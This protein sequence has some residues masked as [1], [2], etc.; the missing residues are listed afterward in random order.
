MTDGHGDDIHR[1]A[2]IRANF[3]SNVYSHFD[4]SGLFAHLARRLECV[5]HYPEPTP[6]SSER[7]VA[8]ALGLQPDEVLVTN[9]ATEGIYLTAQTFRRSRSAIVIPTFSEYADACRMHEHQ[10]ACIGSLSDMPKDTQMAWVCNPNN[11][12]GTVHDK[13]AMLQ[14]VT[15]HADTLFVIDASYAPFTRQPVIAPAEA[16]GL[17][18]VL[19]LHSMTKAF[20]IPGL[21]LGYV[22]GNRAL[23]DKLRSQR[24][25][26]V[27]NSMAQHACE[28]L[29]AHKADYALPVDKLLQERERVAHA[30][31][32][33]GMV[34]PLPSDTHILL[35]R[36]KE[37]KANSLKEH[38]ARHDDLLIRDAS[39]FAG[40]DDRYFRIA[41]QT[42]E[43]NDR[44]TA[45][46]VGYLAADSH[47]HPLL[48]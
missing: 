11:P 34:E 1:Y 23:L 21:R 16:A 4:H 40:L 28:Y 19:M 37:G 17:P 27:V 9:G 13:A 35:C 38:L 47:K 22:I 46:V 43:E 10:T 31:A 30:L 24:M 41:V 2:G 20:A 39:N 44:L 26:W 15:T 6:R 32:A 36:L 3:S 14:T 18:N 25:P 12:T 29:L 5:G 8:E 48:P 33:S 42:S 7:A 45:A